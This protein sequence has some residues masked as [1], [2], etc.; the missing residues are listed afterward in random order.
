MFDQCHCTFAYEPPISDMI[1]RFKDHAGFAECRALSNCFIAHFI[2]FHED[3]ALPWP[4]L[5]LPV[6]LH[7]SRL[8]SRGFNQALLLAQRLS[9]RTGIPVLADSCQRR[10][11]T[12]QRGLNAEDRLHNMQD[13]FHPLTDAALTP[14]RRLAIIDDVVTTTATTQAM[15]RVLRNDATARI[16]VWGLARSNHQPET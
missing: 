3:S 14:R 11:G 6:P 7:P 8:S 5:L 12:A 15:A 4:D 2:G 1:R 16:D 9:R 10:A 13:V